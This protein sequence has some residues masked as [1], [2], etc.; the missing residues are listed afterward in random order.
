MKSTR[1]MILAGVLASAAGC[2]S[3]D[4]F[5]GTWKFTSGET[6]ANCQGLSNEEDLSGNITITEG[7]STDII[8]V[9]SD[10]SVPMD[11]DGDKASID[12]S[13]TCVFPGGDS[14]TFTSFSFTTS[15]GE[16]A[17]WSASGTAR[18]S[19]VDCTFSQSA[20]LEKL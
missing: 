9:D 3:T 12:G 7:S 13:Q 17:R 20:D 8:L 15:D 1:V 14:L 11:I 16:S 4:D 10:C 19:G 5:V 6:K 2:S 18:S